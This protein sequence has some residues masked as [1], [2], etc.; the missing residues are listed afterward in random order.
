MSTR[1]DIIQKIKNIKI[2]ERRT[3]TIYPSKND[4]A[5]SLILYCDNIANTLYK[6]YNFSDGSS[7]T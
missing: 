5:I 3:E 6:S 1:P 7:M 2:L 4:F